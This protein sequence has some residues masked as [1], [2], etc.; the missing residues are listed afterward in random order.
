M[1]REFILHLLLGLIPQSR[2]SCVL[3]LEYVMQMGVKSDKSLGSGDED[4]VV[5]AVAWATITMMDEK[6]SGLLLHVEC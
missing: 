1:S 5:M 2:V 6:W 4:E 3:K